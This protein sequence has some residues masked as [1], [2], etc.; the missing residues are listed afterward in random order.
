MFHEKEQVDNGFFTYKNKICIGFISGFVTRKKW[1]IFNSCLFEAGAEN[2]I[3]SHLSFVE[4]DAN[5]V[6]FWMIYFYILDKSALLLWYEGIQNSGLT[7][8]WRCCPLLLINVLV[9]VII[10]R[11]LIFWPNIVGGL[12]CG[13]NSTPELFH[14][15]LHYGHQDDMRQLNWF[16]TIIW[17]ALEG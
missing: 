3:V 12:I 6:F 13:R 5:F 7:F 8:T 10:I 4:T 17:K 16:T 9:V 15:L 2:L 14:A 1:L 11:P